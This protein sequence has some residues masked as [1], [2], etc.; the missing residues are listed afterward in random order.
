LRG[1]R[2]A[3]ERG[4]ETIR[5]IKGESA[6]SVSDH[7]A[8]PERPSESCSKTSAKPHKREILH[9]PHQSM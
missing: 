3:P 7:A 4:H 8:T 5:R 1:Q 9:Y 2:G 6:T